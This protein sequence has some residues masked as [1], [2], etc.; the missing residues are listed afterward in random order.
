MVRPKT[1]PEEHLEKVTYAHILKSVMM[2]WK[3]TLVNQIACLGVEQL[4][5]PDLPQAGRLAYHLTNWS[6]ITQNQ[7]VLNT[8]RGYQ[9]D[10]E[11]QPTP[12]HYTSEQVILIQEEVAKLLQKHA[13]QPVEC[14]LE[15]DFYSNSFLVPKKDGGQRPVINLKALNS[16]VHPEHFKM[17][18]IQ[19]LKDLLGQGDWLTKVDLK[20]A[21]FAVPIHHANQKHLQFQI[22]GKT[23][24]FTC[25]PFGLSSAPWVFTKTLKPALAIL[26]QRGVRLIAY[27][28]DILLIS[29]SAAQALEHVQA[30]AYLLECLGFTINTEK[31]VLT[32]TQ[33][34]EFLGL[35]VNSIDMELRLP[36]PKIKQIR[37]ES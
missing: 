19:T 37:A 14:P 30:L 34:I 7:W 8:V 11:S 22:Q 20:D 26:R 28:D 1:I 25:L 31:S 18:G 23:F 15:R 35:L 10:F 21:Y 5:Q 24:R 12:P 32:P 29:D 27:I 36:P 17:E 3:S 16:F 9:I 2:N 6:A 33:N 4:C 13:I